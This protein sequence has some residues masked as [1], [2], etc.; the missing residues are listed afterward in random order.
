[1]TDTKTITK[2]EIT[3]ISV[4]MS[5]ENEEFSALRVISVGGEIYFLASELCK[6]LLY[7]N[8]SKAIKD[9]IDPEDIIVKSYKDAPQILK[10]ALWSGADRSKKIL[11][12]ESGFYSLVL[13][14]RQ[15]RAKALKRWITSVVLPSI[16]KNGGYILGQEKSGVE[17]SDLLR[18]TKEK[19]DARTY[20][21]HSAVKQR[22]KYKA[23]AS[24]AK[25]EVAVYKRYADDSAAEA[26]AL[27]AETIEQTKTIAHLR[28]LLAREKEKNAK[29]RKSADADSNSN[30][31]SSNFSSFSYAD[32]STRSDEIRVNK[33]GFVEPDWI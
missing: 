32:N 24:K 12:N 1:M 33:W 7:A 8:N 17:Y 30:A 25:K 26:E 10:E 27:L 2:K 19:L 6:A 13:K 5:K 28:E 23:S 22:D 29:L 31:S 21:W 9:H 11:V 4:Y 15:E 14:S 3:D 20:Y 18:E 16:R